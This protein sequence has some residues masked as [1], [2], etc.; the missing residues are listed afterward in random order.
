VSGRSAGY[1]MV[2]GSPEFRLLG[3]CLRGRAKVNREISTTVEGG[4][5]GSNDFK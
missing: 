3:W 4:L 1:E 2:G 5:G